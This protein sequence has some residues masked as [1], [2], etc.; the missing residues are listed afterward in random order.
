MCQA[1]LKLALHPPIFRDLAMHTRLD[2]FDPCAGFSRCRPSCVFALWLLIQRLFFRTSVPWPYTWKA[3]ILRAFGASI[4]DG[5]VIKP[6]VTIH[7]PWKL[8]VGENSWIG[9]E[10]VILNFENVTIGANSCI[11]QQVFLCAGSHDYRDVAFSYRNAPIIIGEGAWL[12]ARVFVCPGSK[13]GNDSVVLACSLVN[14]DVEENVISGWR[15]VGQR[16]IRWTK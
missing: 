13:I 11:S 4:G 15:W 9:E 8:V 6:R 16:K 5:V 1:V 14:D 2:L 3:S 7:F 10:V 12:Q